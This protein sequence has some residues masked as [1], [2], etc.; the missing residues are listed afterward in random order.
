[1]TVVDFVTS[2]VAETELVEMFVGFT[3]SLFF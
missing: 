3:P 1:M 2:F